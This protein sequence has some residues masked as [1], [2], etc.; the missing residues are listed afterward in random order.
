MKSY[1]EMNELEYA[2]AVTEY[3]DLL[4][5]LADGWTEADVMNDMMEC[6]ER[7]GDGF[8]ET[9]T[10]E[11]LENFAKSVHREIEGEK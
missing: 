6:I 7:G 11:Q 10:G 1:E 8:L 5:S 3:A 9:M 2:E 4:A